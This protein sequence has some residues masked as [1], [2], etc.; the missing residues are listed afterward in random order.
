M[1]DEMRKESERLSCCK[2]PSL[3]IAALGMLDLM[4]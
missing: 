3:V 4:Y 2:E 1:G